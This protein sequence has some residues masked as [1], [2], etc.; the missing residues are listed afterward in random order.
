M[1]NLGPKYVQSLNQILTVTEHDI[2]MKRHLKD[3]EIHM[4]NEFSKK[5][6]DLT[7]YFTQIEKK[8]KFTGLERTKLKDKLRNL[9]K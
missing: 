8:C 7:R 6:K 4:K 3:H 1:Y 5:C 9:K 2:Q